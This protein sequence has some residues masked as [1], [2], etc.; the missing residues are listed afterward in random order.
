MNTHFKLAIKPLAVVVL[1]SGL[2]GCANTNAQHVDERIAEIKKTRV[3]EAESLKSLASAVQ[4]EERYEAWAAQ[5][6]ADIRS[7]YESD[8][9]V[10]RST[11]NSVDCRTSKCA[12]QFQVTG[13][14]S[15][16]GAVEQQIAI[17]EWIAA[18]E[19]CG[20]T[21]TME[22]GSKQSQGVVRIF[23]DCRNR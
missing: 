15:V 9:S 1:T 18:N 16:K 8:K 20:Y 12:L 14:Q 11:L 3:Q 2:I 19:P 6:E 13:E 4:Q 10:P 7:S 21:L 22:P 17:N 23:L 5:K